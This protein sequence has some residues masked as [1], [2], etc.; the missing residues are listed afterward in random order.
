MRPRQLLLL[1]VLAV[2]A[3][4]CAN[5]DLGRSTPVCPPDEDVISA[6]GASMVLQLQAVDTAEYVP[7][8]NDLNAGWQYEDLVSERGMSRFWLDSD[9]L[10]SRFLE[11][12]LTASCEVEDLTEVN[13]SMTTSANTGTSSWSVR[14]S[15]WSSC[16]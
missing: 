1:V 2:A 16:R 8:L 7:C 13:S 14:R 9:R 15:P 6:V 5:S 11:V 10:G 3:A 4:G 12:T